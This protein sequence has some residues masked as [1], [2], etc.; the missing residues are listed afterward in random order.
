MDL[1][2]D[3]LR[4]DHDLRVRDRGVAYLRCG[5]E[6]P[7][8][9]EVSLQPSS[10]YDLIPGFHGLPEAGLVDAHEVEASLSIGN[11]VR[12][13]ERENAG[14]LCQRLND[15]DARHDRPFREMALNERLVVRYVLQRP[16]ALTAAPL[17]HSVDEQERMAVWKLPQNP[18]DIE[19]REVSHHSLRVWLPPEVGMLGRLR[20]RGHEFEARPA[21]AITA[22]GLPNIG[23]SRRRVGLQ[24]SVR[25]RAESFG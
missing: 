25:V 6:A 24:M 19:S 14:R 22:D 2:L 10:E 1:L 3:G 4:R 13:E 15:E 7:D 12:A 11:D 23:V 20:P 9:L 21:D 5:G 16:D 18:L 17:E 8:A